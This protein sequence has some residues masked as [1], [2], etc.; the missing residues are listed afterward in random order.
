MRSDGI[1]ILC[2]VVLLIFWNFLYF[3]LKSNHKQPQEDYHRLKGDFYTAPEDGIYQF[4]P[5]GI[6][7]IGPLPT[8]K[9]EEN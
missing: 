2:L 7:K 8:P 9:K 3:K 1:I 4:G 6:K 5:D